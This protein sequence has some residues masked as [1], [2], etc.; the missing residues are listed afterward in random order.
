[1]IKIYLICAEIGGEKLHK[2]GYTKRTIEQ[3]IKEFKTGNASDFYIVDSFQSKWGTK[4][5]SQLHRHFRNKKLSGEWFKLSD[6]DISKFREL[7]ERIDSNLDIISKGTYYLDN[8]D[9]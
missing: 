3:R 2:I 9:F 6:S 7:C 5:E 8:G 4:V 1:M